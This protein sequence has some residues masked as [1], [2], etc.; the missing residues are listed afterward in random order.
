MAPAM[1]LAPVPVASPDYCNRSGPRVQGRVP[2]ATRTQAPWQRRR[3]GQGVAGD[4]VP[5]RASQDPAA[6]P[7]QQ[8]TG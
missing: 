8:Q 6:E 7:Q 1:V 4:V 3:L 5:A 2:Q